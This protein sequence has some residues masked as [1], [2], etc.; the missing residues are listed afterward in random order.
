MASLLEGTPSLCLYINSALT[1]L[2]ER[3]C[4]KQADS[5]E[6]K[7]ANNLDSRKQKGNQYQCQSTQ[8]Q[9]YYNLCESSDEIPASKH[10][11]QPTQNN[12]HQSLE[13]CAQHN[14]SP[15]IVSFNIDL[16]N[17]IIQHYRNIF[18]YSICH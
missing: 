5:G 13:N 4:Q 3:P 17:F 8:H 16:H 18:K 7:P 12:R 15:S 1:Q 2:N 11:R 10:N 6:Q 14:D 9:T